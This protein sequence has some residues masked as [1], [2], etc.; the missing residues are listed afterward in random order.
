MSDV[1]KV[2]TCT[3]AS[4][5][6][7]SSEVDL[8]RAYDEVYLEYTSGVTFEIFIQGSRSA[9]GSFKRIYFPPA[10]GTTNVSAIEI[11]SATAGA[12]GAI[13]PLPHQA[14]YM[15]LEAG[16]SVANGATFYFICRD[17]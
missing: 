9:S 12:N 1:F 13:V 8:K 11:N 6:T 16:T 10:D 17:S 4:G 5:A 7:S 2:Y 14:P 15:K 3:F